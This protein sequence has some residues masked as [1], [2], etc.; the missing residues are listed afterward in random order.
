MATIPLSATSSG[1]RERRALHEATE[2]LQPDE[3]YHFR[4]YMLCCATSWISLNFRLH[5]Q[6]TI[7]ERLAGVMSPETAHALGGEIS[8]SSKIR[9]CILEVVRPVHGTRRVV[10]SDNYY[11]SVQLLEA[12]RVKGLYSRGTVRK[13]SALSAPC[14]HQKEGILTGGI[15][16]SRRQ[17][18]QYCGCLL[19]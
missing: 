19:V 14:A 18:A 2:G 7:N 15:T 5:C 6:S 1:A 12:L 8:S 10:N 17:P 4:I 11:T 13:S 16:T 3:T 9:Q